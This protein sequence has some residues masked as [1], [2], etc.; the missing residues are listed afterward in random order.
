MKI[1]RCKPIYPGIKQNKYKRWV[2][3]LFSIFKY[4]SF[5]YSLYTVYQLY[6]GV[7]KNP[8]FLLTV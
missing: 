3:V 8:V 5:P 1:C 4:D 6:I 7:L 2:T